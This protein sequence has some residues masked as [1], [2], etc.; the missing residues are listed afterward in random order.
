M[1]HINKEKTGKDNCGKP[2][3]IIIGFGNKYRSDDGIGIRVIEEIEKLDFFDGLEV[4]DGGTSGTDLIIL[5]RDYKKIIIV[6]AI[7]T[8]THAEDEVVC[9]NA[10][11]IGQPS[12]K[13]YKSFSLHDMDLSDTLR[14]IK[15]L[16]LNTEIVIIGIKPVNTGFG[17]SLSPEI[18]NKIPRIISM[19]KE[20]IDIWAN[21]AKGKIS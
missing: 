13:G 9:I 1:L 18:E 19:I 6:D 11:N 14:I 20:K 21:P 8:F 10:G 16:G 4:L 5:A 7:D 15:A 2:D 17:D 12:E 3:V